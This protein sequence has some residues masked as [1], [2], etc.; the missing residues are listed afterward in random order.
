MCMLITVKLV[1]VR[2]LQVVVKT[3]SQVA[4]PYCLCC[5]QLSTVKY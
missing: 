2:P 4:G 3:L 5:S 1:A